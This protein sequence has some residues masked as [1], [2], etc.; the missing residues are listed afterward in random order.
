MNF[1]FPQ[2]R[3]RHI[4]SAS[5]LPAQDGFVVIDGDRNLGDSEHG[6]RILARIAIAAAISLGPVNAEDTDSPEPE[7]AVEI[8]QTGDTTYRYGK[9]SF[10]KKDR[11]VRIPTK[12]VQ[13]NV[14][15]EYALVHKNGKTHE[16]I[17]STEASAMRLHT[18]LLLLH[19]TQSQEMLNQSLPAEMAV[20]GETAEDKA[21]AQLTV[22]V[23]W[24][25][26]E[27]G[28]EK[29]APL[30]SWI[31]HI[32]E[33]D[34]ELPISPGPFTL[35]GSRIYD[36][37]FVAEIDGNIFALYLDPTALINNPREG[38]FDDEYWYTKE[39]AIPPIDT[40]VTLVFSPA[41]TR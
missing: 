24:K 35:T 11:S 17:L 31:V 22:A 10:D 21:G 1:H 19:Y 14:A 28:A 29:T 33:D 40:E 7:K 13:R 34:A 36:G 9:I 27:T 32:D 39:S 6:T 23:S 30:E 20:S 5:D 4:Q 16:S 26:P 2:R 12:V 41:L 37:K 25:D 15:L 3:R 18:V 38:N 8:E